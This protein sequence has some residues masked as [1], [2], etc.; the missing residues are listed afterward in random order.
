MVHVQVT[1]GDIDSALVT[2]LGPQPAQSAAG[3][4]DEQSAVVRPNLNRGGV[5]AVA[6]RVRA[7][8]GDRAPGAP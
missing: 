6:H 5:A 2:Q 7:G 3:I 1:Q 4:E 8:T